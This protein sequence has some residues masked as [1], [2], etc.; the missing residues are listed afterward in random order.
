MLEDSAFDIQAEIDFEATEQFA[1]REG[2]EFVFGTG[3]GEMEGILT[4]AGV[5]EVVSGAATAITSDGLISLKYGVKSAYV[6]NANFLMNRAT[7]STVRKLKDLNGMYIWMPGLAQ[8]RPNTIDGDPYVEMPDMP[9]EGAGLYP[10]AYGDFRRA[11][12]MLDRIAMEMLRD[13]YTQ[14]TG[15]AVRFIFRRRAGGKVVL[16]EA[17]RK[18][19]CS[20]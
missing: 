4:N 2:M 5:A 17:I 19:K 11:Y 8:G 10:V 3:I 20:T 13:P 12:T 9:V 1:V 16:A 6:A 7:I 18:M 14:A 15:G